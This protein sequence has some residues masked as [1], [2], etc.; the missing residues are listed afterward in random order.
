LFQIPADVCRMMQSQWN[1]FRL[2]GALA[3]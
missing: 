1:R 2:F 3:D